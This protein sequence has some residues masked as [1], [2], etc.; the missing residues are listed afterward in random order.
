MIDPVSAYGVR[1]PHELYDRQPVETGLGQEVMPEH[2]A[3]FE[4]ALGINGPDRV[5]G[6]EMKVVQ[7][8]GGDVWIAQPPAAEA[9]TPPPTSL[10]DSILNGLENLRGSW[11]E[12]MADINQLA[13]DPQLDMAQMMKLQ[14]QVQHTAVMTQMVL[15]EVKSIDQEVNKLLTAS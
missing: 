15:N 5:D 9:Q 14:F 6:T 3:R 12:T 11:R 2:Q 4:A 10:G 8:D 7:A 1:P 13:A